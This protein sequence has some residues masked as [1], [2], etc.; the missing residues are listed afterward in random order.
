MSTKSSNA[1]SNKGN[2]TKKIAGCMTAIFQLF[3]HKQLPGR[4]QLTGKDHKKDEGH[5]SISSRQEAEC[6]EFY[7]LEKNLGTNIQESPRSSMTSSRISSSSTTASSPRK[8][9]QEKQKHTGQ[10][11]LSGSSQKSSS[12]PSNSDVNKSLGFKGSPY[13]DV[14]RERAKD[15]LS[16]NKVLQP[17]DSPRPK[18]LIKSKDVEKSLNILMKLKELSQNSHGVCYRLAFH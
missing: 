8:S 9:P 2:D 6:N 12:I 16:R 18:H 17:V 5:A 11:L 14:Q 13:R 3:D 1:T 10:K 15:R 4:R 7:S